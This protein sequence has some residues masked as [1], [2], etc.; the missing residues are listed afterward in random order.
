MSDVA[1]TDFPV[2]CAVSVVTQGE[3]VQGEVFA[4]DSASDTVLIHQQGSTPFHSNLRFLKVAYLKSVQTGASP[5]RPVAPLPTVDAQ[6]CKDRE[7]KALQAAQA[8]AAKTGVG[9]SNEAQQV[10]DALSKTMP[11]QWKQQNIV[12]LNEVELS[13][14]YG[15]DNCSTEHSHN[16]TTLERVKKVV[17]LYAIL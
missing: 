11:C 17:S 4:F 10:F 13:P 7:V 15:L 12:I 8:E 9:V 1:A 3:E 5:G 6:R 14:P 2:G 16:V